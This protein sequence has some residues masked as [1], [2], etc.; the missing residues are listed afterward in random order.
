MKQ[1]AKYLGFH[2][3]KKLTL[4]THIKAKRKQLKLKVRNMNWLINKK[5]QLSLENKITIYKEIIKP[6][7]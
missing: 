6:M 5:P 7:G 2:L 1:E 4:Q 3:D